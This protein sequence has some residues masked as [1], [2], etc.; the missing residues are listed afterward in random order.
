MRILATVHLV[1][2]LFFCCPKYTITWLQ[3]T[4]DSFMKKQKVTVFKT[5]NGFYKMFCNFEFPH[6]KRRRG[7]PR[8]TWRRSWEAEMKEAGLDWHSMVRMSREK[9]C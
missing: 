1:R 8:N 3:G 6:G 4:F 7:R 5:L 9:C 2:S